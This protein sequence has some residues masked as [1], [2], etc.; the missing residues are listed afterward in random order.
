[1]AIKWIRRLVEPPVALR[2]TMPFTKARSSS[3]SATGVYSL[4]SAE[5]A[6]AR[7][8]PS[9]VRASRSGVPGLTK[10]APGRW[11]PMNSISIWLVLAVP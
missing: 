6:R 7:L 1:M 4:P 10:L 5:M 8:A 2:P 3:K 11:R 9:T